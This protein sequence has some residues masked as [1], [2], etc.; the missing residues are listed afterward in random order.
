[1]EDQKAFDARLNNTATARDLATLLRALESGRAAS[2]PATSEMRDVLMAQE[3]NEK[4]PAGLPRGIRVAHK[5]GDIT[6]IAHDAAIVY[7][8]GRAPYILVVLT[9][10]IEPEARADSL[11]AGISSDIYAY[12]MRR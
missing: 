4:I 9:K 12:A 5:T 10:G 7:P 6:A 8:A 2:P 3:F 1:V 11:I